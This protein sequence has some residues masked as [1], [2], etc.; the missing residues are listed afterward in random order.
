[1]RKVIVSEFISLD[2]IIEDPGGAEKSIHG[3]WT[4]SYWNDEIGK[5][6][7]EELFA[8]D[9]L[10]LGRITYQGFAAAW[11][12]MKDEAGFADRMNGLPKYVVTRTLEKGDWNNT[13]LIKGD[14]DEEISNLKRQP[15]QDM[16]VA[17]SA[18]LVQSLAR[19]GLVD[20]YRLLVYPVALGSG[21]R[22]FGPDGYATLDLLETKPMG[23]GVVAMIYEPAKE[24][25]GKQG[26]GRPTS[27]RD[28]AK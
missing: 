5:F 13:H 21:K 9:A 22:L 7:S 12:S 28:V 25:A 20:V 27:Y 4:W 18:Q 24:A 6:K 16:L 17:G 26:A 23:K 10:L 1:M 14:L 8:S 15:G 3:G 19:A 11:P 2:G